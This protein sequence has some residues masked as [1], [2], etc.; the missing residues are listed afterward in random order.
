MKKKN[1]NKIVTGKNIL[2][3]EKNLI[4]KKNIENKL[5]QKKISNH[6]LQTNYCK[7]N[8][9]TNVMA[10]IFIFGKKVN[11]EFLFEKEN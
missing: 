8:I 3:G 10:K 9:Q 6:K 11:S 7:K 5:L 2:F 4:P 1:E